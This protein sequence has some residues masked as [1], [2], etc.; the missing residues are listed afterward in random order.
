M[1]K[2]FY[3][4]RDIDDMKA[5]GVDSIDVTDNIVLTDLA[6]E[7]AMKHGMK[8]NRRE[9]SSPQAIYSPSV[10]TY[11]AYAREAPRPSAPD[12]ELKQRIKSAVLARLNGQVDEVLLEAVITRVLAGMQ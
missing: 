3:T 5:S 11:A 9:Q 1:A 12:P 10:N 4:E 6:V 7:R 8:I 2:I